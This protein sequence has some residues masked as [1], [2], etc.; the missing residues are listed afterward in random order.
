MTRRL[1]ACGFSELVESPSEIL[2]REIAALVQVAAFDCFGSLY[3]RPANHEA[4][5]AIE[6]FDQF[7]D[8]VRARVPAQID[9][10]D[11]RAVRWVRLVKARG[12]ARGVRA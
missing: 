4:P 1:A 2:G 7:L 3:I 6:D 11:V 8:R 12:F 10:V 9:G 5:A